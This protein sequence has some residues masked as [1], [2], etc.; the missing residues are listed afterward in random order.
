MTEKSLNEKIK[1]LDEK[2]EW[3]YSDGFKLENAVDNYKDALKLSE[4]IE[5]DLKNLKNEIEI[6]DK[7]FTKS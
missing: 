7:D 1:E 3:F 5:K 6:L 4:E 2:V